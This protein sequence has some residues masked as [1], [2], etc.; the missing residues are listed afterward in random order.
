VIRIVLRW[1]LSLGVLAALLLWLEPRKI[2][3][4]LAELDFVWLLPALLAATV[5]TLLS[6]WRW[7][8]TAARLGLRLPARTALGDY[9][10]AGFVNQVLP[11]GVVGDAWR[12]QR[13]ASSSGRTGPAWRAV[14]LER[15]SG[16][17]VVVLLAVLA[18]LL[19]E[20]WREAIFSGLVDQ[21]GSGRRGLAWGLPLALAV[22]AYATRRRWQPLLAVL[23]TDIRRALLARRA[24]PVQLFSST[25]IVLCYLLTFALAG[26]G[27]GLELS[28][29][30]LMLLALPVL[31][32]MLIPLSVAGWGFREGAAAGVWLFSALPPE[33]G[34]A[35]SITYGLIVLLASLP[36]AWVLVLRPSARA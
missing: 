11:G 12:A 2:A 27:L 3:A 33:Q 22:L 7:R 16:Q 13:H 26:R 25:L 6:A 20:P 35:A 32:A 30:H 31:L 1:A 19:H 5:P 23:G 14:I 28:V 36:G 34:V 29:P 17:L 24:W 4:Q 18:L 15:A 9:Y 10:L 8:F 21:A